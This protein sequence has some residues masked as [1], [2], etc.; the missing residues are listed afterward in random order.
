[1]IIQALAFDDEVRSFRKAHAFLA[2]SDTIHPWD[3]TTDHRFHHDTSRAILASARYAIAHGLHVLPTTASIFGCY[4]ISRADLS[5]E[6]IKSI[7]LTWVAWEQEM[8]AY[9]TR[10]I[11]SHFLVKRIFYVPAI[12]IQ[13]FPLFLPDRH[14]KYASVK[15]I[16]EG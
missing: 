14:C 9:C 1:M 7:E 10:Q 15:K 3:V 2:S 13:P 5:M 12:S 11:K 8:F 16:T 4:G 6:L